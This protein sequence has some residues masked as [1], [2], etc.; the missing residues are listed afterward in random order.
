MASLLGAMS[1]VR[2]V[3]ER[4]RVT[5][6]ELFF[7]L[8]YVFAVTRVTAYMAEAHSGEGVLQG[9]LLLGLLWW[10]WA[11]YSWLGNQAR[12][13]TGVT[14][15]AMLVAM[16]AIFVV[17]LTIPEAW[18]DAPG[19][20]NGPVVLVVAYFLVRSIHLLVYA[21]AAAGDR[22][23]R[24]QLVV[25]I[26]PMVAGAALLLM[27]ALLGGTAQ[28]ILFAGGLGVDWLGTWITSRGGA[29]R[30]HGP[31][32]WCERHGLFVIL[33]IGESL[34]AVGTGAAQLPISAPLIGGAVLGI[35]VSVSLWSLYFDVV[36]PAAERA[37]S[38]L[39]GR[40]RVDIAVEAYSYL[41][42]P[43]IAGIVLAALGVEEVLG[44]V[45]ET[46]ALG[47]FAAWAL[48]GGLALYLLGHVAFKW[49]L[50]GTINRQRLL[51][52]AVLV[53]TAPLSAH[54]PPLL[55]LGIA[56]VVLG[57]LMA[58]EA[59][60]YAELRESLRDGMPEPP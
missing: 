24:H 16:A 26:A 15:V 6:F 40:A 20:L 38:A 45:D 54:V 33:A 8:V 9:L 31:A 56:V 60:R 10:T 43:I 4:H 32:H 13:D 46:A 19:G 37:L 34:V 18:E 7:D 52:A 30:I 48:H 21:V 35:A 2:A 58:Y 11:A 22:E 53:A 28:T 44:H 25:T 27:G 14:R 3:D 55:A 36:S 50:H 47:T 57:G 17:A 51:A 59:A 12:A 1:R 49:R 23:L 5:S 29:W 42:F 41:H 39:T